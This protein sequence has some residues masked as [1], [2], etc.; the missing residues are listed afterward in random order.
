MHS[1]KKTVLH[2]HRVTYARSHDPSLDRSFDYDHV[3]RLR[4]SHSGV[5]ARMH[6]SN[7]PND[8]GALGPYAH[9]YNYDVWGNLT[10]RLGWGGNHGAYVNETF[11]Y[12]RNRRVDFGYDNAGNLTFDG[13]HY[14]YNAQG[15]QVNAT[16]PPSWNGYTLQQAYDG[17]GLR[18]KKVDGGVTTY[19]V[20]SSVLGNQVVA[21][22]NQGGGWQR[23][24]VY[25]GGHLLAIQQAGT[26]NWVHQDPVTKSQRLTDVNGTIIAA[27]DVDPWGGETARSSSSHLQP[28]KYTSYERDGSGN[29][30]AM[31]RQY[32][33]FWQRFDQPDPYD[34]SMN[35]AD[36]QSLNRYAYVQ[37][38]PVNFVDPSGLNLSSITAIP[39][40]TSRV[41]RRPLAARSGRRVG[42]QERTS[43]PSASLRPVS[44][45]A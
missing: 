43:A 7:Q 3:G 20:R 13:G 27:I 1:C 32:H 23:G 42:R 29:D 21:E 22:V 8:G 24:Y 5:E 37:N 12:D 2:S 35:P 11:S 36:P 33:S 44:R 41:S 31:Y 6:V 34:G 30:Q 9:H 45:R 40:V 4:Y 14:T 17:D 25:L 38:D 28:R 26:V 18:V 15:Q 10:S 19:A 39:M 16:Y